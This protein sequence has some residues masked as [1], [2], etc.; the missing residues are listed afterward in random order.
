MHLFH[1]V[2]IIHVTFY[3]FDFLVMNSLHGIWIREILRYCERLR[4][5]KTET[6]AILINQEETNMSGY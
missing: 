1:V 2:L 6:N 5:W 4:K 3:L